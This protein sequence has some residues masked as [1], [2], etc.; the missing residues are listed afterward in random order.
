MNSE[1]AA[2]LDRAIGSVKKFHSQTFG[3]RIVKRLDSLHSVDDLHFC[4]VLVERLHKVGREWV[5]GYLTDKQADRAWDVLINEKAVTPAEGEI[6][7]DFT[8]DI[9]GYEPGVG[10]ANTTR[11]TTIWAANDAAALRAAEAEIGSAAQYRW[12]EWA[13][14]DTGW[15]RHR[16][17][18]EFNASWM[19]VERA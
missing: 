2:K 9:W 17:A 13:R 19:R 6:E 7:Y 3:E 18:V 10:K 11:K 4:D 8:A 5:L 1:L 16:T 15:E 12:S 14:D